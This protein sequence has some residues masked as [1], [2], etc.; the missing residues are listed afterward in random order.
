MVLCRRSRAPTAT[1]PTRTPAG[2]APC[3]LGRAAVP[4]GAGSGL[5]Q[6]L[7]QR[8]GKKVIVDAKVDAGLIGGAGRAGR[9]PGAGRQRPHPARA[10]CARSSSTRDGRTR[11]S[12]RNRH[13]NSRRRD[14]PDHPQADRGLR[15]EGRGH[16]DRHRA[17]PSATASRA[18]TAWTARWPASCSSSRGG[19]VGHGAEP[20][21]GQRRRRAP[22]RLRG[23]SARATRS[24]APARSP[25]V[26]VGEAL[27]GRVVE[28]ARRADRRQGPD[29]LDQD[30]AQGRDQGARHRRP[31]VGARAAA[32]RH[33]GDRRDDPDRPRPAR[34][35]HRRPPDRQDRGR[36][37]HDHQPE[38]PGRD[39]H[40]RRHRPEAV[41]GRRGRRQAA[42]RPARWS[43]RIV[44]AATAS[45][46]APL[47]FIAPYTGVTMGEYFR[48]NGRH[49]LIVYDDLSK[50][51][52]AYRQLSLLLRR[53]P[54]REAY[55]GDVFYLHSR[56]LERAAK[57][58]DERGRRLA[59][60]AA[61]HRDPGR[62]RVGVHPDQRHL[63]HRR[64]DL[65]REPTCSTRAS[66]RPSTSASRCR[67]SAAPRR[68]RR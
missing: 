28:R 45:E 65:P 62:R 53:P 50:Q 7:E 16:R 13:A 60:R 1:S 49:A 11:R 42:P 21:G 64:P 3:D 22:R 46:P 37:R 34:A 30:V 2:S 36:D 61:D 66:A 68:S 59:D 55:P 17:R 56:L 48:D 57:L 4:G 19:V 44:V 35:D 67:A 29:R 23:R 38:G 47:Q 58:S 27:I 26:P 51:A 10:T 39:L 40:L 54:G 5:A 18:S 41:D 31:Q 63:D 25:Q 24:S 43:T 33:Q 8:T 52:V 15:Q 20:R 6:S 9:R 32:D 12:G 14:Q